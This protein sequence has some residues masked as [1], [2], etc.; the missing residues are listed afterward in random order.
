[1]IAMSGCAKRNADRELSRVL[2]LVARR[3]AEAPTSDVRHTL[4]L[5]RVDLEQ[6]KHRDSP[7]D[8]PPRPG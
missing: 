7:A 8:E 6:R 4:A 1:M 3:I 2:V 5:L